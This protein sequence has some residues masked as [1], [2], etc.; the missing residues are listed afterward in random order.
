MYKQLASL[1]VALFAIVNIANSQTLFTY[2]KKAVTK[3]E[4]LKAFN[5]NPSLEKDRK[6]ALREYLD[7]YTSFK[8]KVQ[9]AFDAK[10]QNDPNYQYETENFK[11]QLAANFIN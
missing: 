3:E 8:L 11:K 9:A 7:L 6:K 4:F 10:L 1:V 2:G 5:K